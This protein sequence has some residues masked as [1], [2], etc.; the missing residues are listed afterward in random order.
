MPLPAAPVTSTAAVKTWLRIQGTTD[1]ADLDDIVAAVDDLVRGLASV[2]RIS[3]T[4]AADDAW[5]MR[6]QLGAKMLAGRLL[7]RRNSPEGV[8]SFVGEGVAYVRRVD[9]DVAAMLRLNLP[10]A[11]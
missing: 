8:A 9:P 1:D 3:E 11:G 7:R 5:P 4:L 10:S 6:Y 2:E